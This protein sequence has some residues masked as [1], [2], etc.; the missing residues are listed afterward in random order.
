MTDGE[1]NLFAK[2]LF[3]YVV[4][5][6]LRILALCLVAFIVVYLIAD[7]SDRID[8]FLKHDAPISL[9]VRYFLAKI[10]L[11]VNQVLPIAVLAA[12]LLSLGGLSRHNELT[13]MKASGIS[14]AQI[15][16]PLLATCL[17]LSLGAFLWTENVV[18]HFATR[19]H[20][21]NTVEIKKRQMQGVLGDQQIW[22]HGQETFYNIQSFDTRTQTLIGVTIY[23]IDPAFHLK[24]L[25][26]VPQATWDGRQWT[27]RDGV[28]RRF[29]PTGEIETITLTA[30]ALDL[31]EKP[32]D[33]MAA[34]RD[35]D[36]FNYRELH[37]MVERLR[38][39]GLDTTEYA[40]DL[41]LKLAVPFICAV[42]GLISMPLGMRSLRSSSL[43]NNIATGLLIGATYWFVLALAV[44]LGHSG[45]LPPVVAAWTANVIFT[46]I[47]AFLLLAP[48]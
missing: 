39:K 31:R 19:A 46:G 44:S 12:M 41:H 40:V 42:M 25:V 28:E 45:A 34:H 16:A 14:P 13:A 32:D 47:G 33:L 35:A 18:P 4:G 2:I 3:R 17:A 5:E 37:G 38:K 15:V 20:Y 48:A 30:G 23:P 36:E 10:P 29:T 9:I 8:D 26:E 6:F 21:I 27:F 11:I 22:A 43:A 24:G 1:R 7:F